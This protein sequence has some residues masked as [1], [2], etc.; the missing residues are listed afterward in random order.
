MTSLNLFTTKFDQVLDILEKRAPSLEYVLVDTP[1]QI[2]IFTWSASGAIITETLAAT[3]PTVVCYIMDTPRCVSPAT[4][5]SNMLYACSIMYKTKLPFVLVFNK[6][7]VQCHKFAVEWM[8]NYDAF[9][10]ALQT[11]TTYMGS[12]VNSMSLVLEEFY[13]QLRVTCYYYFNTYS[14]LL[15]C[16]LALERDWTTFWR[17]WTKR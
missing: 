1:G 6:T 2:E 8:Q 12:L 16:L 11:D 5:M 15:A 13:N 4:F 10:E 3:Y 7:D 14:R 17:Q 9:Q